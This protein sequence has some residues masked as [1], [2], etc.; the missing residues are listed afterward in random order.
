MTIFLDP[1]V[2]SVHCL[3]GGCGAAR[4]LPL[5]TLPLGALA[6][7]DAAAL[8]LSVLEVATEQAAARC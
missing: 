6:R 3:Q 5:L 7:L 4:P 1:D 2:D 8:D